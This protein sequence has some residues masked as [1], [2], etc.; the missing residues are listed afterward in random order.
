MCLSVTLLQAPL[1][2]VM[3]AVKMPKDVRQMHGNER[4]FWDGESSLAS[5]QTGE[6]GEQLLVLRE[7]WRDELA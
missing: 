7:D 1:A 3:T 6:N 5:L 4:E 2:D